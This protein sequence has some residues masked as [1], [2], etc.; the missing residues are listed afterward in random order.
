MIILL[1]QGFFV[2]TSAEDVVKWRIDKNKSENFY[3][4]FCISLCVWWDVMRTRK[5]RSSMQSTFINILKRI[6]RRKGVTNPCVYMWN[7]MKE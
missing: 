3:F 2:D 4:S 1:E 5:V 7:Q 6:E